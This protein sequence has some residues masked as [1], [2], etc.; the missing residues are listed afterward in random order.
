MYSSFLRKLKKLKAKRAQ[1]SKKS[2]KQYSRGRRQ[3]NVYSTVIKKK[4]EEEKMLWQ[5]AR[6][7]RN[8]AQQLGLRPAPLLRA[9]PRLRI[10]RAG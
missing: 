10:T 3:E 1:N 6:V 7:E 5:A 2:P 8:T 4:V 9:V